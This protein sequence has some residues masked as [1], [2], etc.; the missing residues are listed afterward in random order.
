MVLC[1][2]LP[3]VR[4][5][6]PEQ[7]DAGVHAIGVSAPPEPIWNTD[8]VL[9]V[10]SLASPVEQPVAASYPDFLDPGD[11]SAARGRGVVRDRAPAS[12][13][14]R[15]GRRLPPWSRDVPWLGC[16]RDTVRVLTRITFSDVPRI[17]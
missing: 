12:V 13:R 5:R 2:G 17:R 16:L 7:L 6:L 8:T 10:A 15:Q 4:A 11:R 1:A 14:S 3:L 9:R